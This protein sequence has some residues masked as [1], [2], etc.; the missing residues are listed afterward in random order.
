MYSENV[1]SVDIVA[2]HTHYGTFILNYVYVVTS[3]HACI[4]TLAQ[5]GFGDG[6]FSSPEGASNRLDPS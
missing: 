5:D 6:L 2:V 3:A 4:L 1:T